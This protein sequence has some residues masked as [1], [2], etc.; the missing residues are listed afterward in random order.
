MGFKEDLL[1]KLVVLLEPYKI[2]RT[3]D[4]PV[5]DS[6]GSPIVK[7]DG[8]IDTEQKTIASYKTED[9]PGESF[10]AFDTYNII[11]SDSLSEILKKYYNSEKIVMHSIKDY[12]LTPDVPT[13]VYEGVFYRTNGNRMRFLNWI[14]SGDELYIT[15]GVT[16]YQ[17]SSNF[18][19]EETYHFEFGHY[20]NQKIVDMTVF[21]NDKYFIIL[22]QATATGLTSRTI[23][24]A[25]GEIYM[26]YDNSDNPI[27]L[28]SGTYI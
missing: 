20:E 3:F 22:Y 16:L 24:Y 14:K 2:N 27:N 1:S 19:V 21:D 10:K 13:D 8:S 12:A 26:N 18:S 6:N 25:Y 5:K 23:H 7:D 11:A 4:L 15:S 17:L 9:D 28:T